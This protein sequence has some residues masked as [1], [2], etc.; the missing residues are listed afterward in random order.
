M[1]LWHLTKD[2][3]RLPDEPRGGQR[4]QVC[5]G[6]SPIA[7]GQSVWVSL[8]VEHG[9]H[10]LEHRVCRGMWTHNDGPNSY[11]TIELGTFAPGDTVRYRV[12]GEDDSGQICSG[13]KFKFIVGPAVH[14]ETANYDE[15][16][17]RARSS[18]TPPP[19]DS[20]VA[21]RW[22]AEAH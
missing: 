10:T 20:G 12:I 11:W 6:T 5:V 9:D 1:E 7:L 22:S 15:S 16:L 18:M 17:A 13:Q 8:T 3:S 2:T 4:V 19:P 14:L 21:A